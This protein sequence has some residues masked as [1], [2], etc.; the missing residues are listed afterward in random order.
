MDGFEIRDNPEL[1]RLLREAKAKVEAMTPAERADMLRAQ[2][3]SWARAE[4]AWPKPIF[5]YINGVKVYASY[6]DYCNG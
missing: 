1:T 2:A 4:A 3:E 5:K 6:S